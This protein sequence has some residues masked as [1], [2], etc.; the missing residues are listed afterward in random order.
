MLIDLRFYSNLFQFLDILSIGDI[1]KLRSYPYSRFN[2]L[3]VF[4]EWMIQRLPETPVPMHIPMP[5]RHQHRFPRKEVMP[6]IRKVEKIICHFLCGETIGSLLLHLVTAFRNRILHQPRWHIWSGTS[7]GCSAHTPHRP[8]T[9]FMYVP[10]LLLPLSSYLMILP[11][12]LP[13][14]FETPSSK[15]THRKHSWLL[16]AYHIIM[17][18]KIIHRDKLSIFE[19]RS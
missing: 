3:G 14:I 16:S 8:T 12:I 1:S 18:S 7:P 9:D 6:K 17:C 5:T 15:D 2:I 13:T 4:H 11:I 10:A 19:S